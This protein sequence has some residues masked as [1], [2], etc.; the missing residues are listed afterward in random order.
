MAMVEQLKEHGERS[1]CRCT[2]DASPDLDL[3][4]ETARMTMLF[5]RYS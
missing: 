3:E 4:M 5:S 1:P 2:E